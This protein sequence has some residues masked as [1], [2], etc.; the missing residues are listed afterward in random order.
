MSRDWQSF[1]AD[2]LTACEKVLKFTTGMD[3]EA[4]FDDDRTYHAVIHCLL[5]VGEAAK[6]IPEDIRQRYPE[7]EWKK[8]AGMRDF[9]VHSYFAIDDEILWDAI[10]TKV[11]ELLRTLRDFEDREQP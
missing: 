6:R 3:R 9:M 1:H 5:I 8:I 7:V 10:E 2:I 4:F 11:P